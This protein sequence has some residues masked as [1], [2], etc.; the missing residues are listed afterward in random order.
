MLLDNTLPVVRYSESE[1]AAL[2]GKIVDAAAKRTAPAAAANADATA[3]AAAATAIATVASAARARPVE[4]DDP[5]EPI[6]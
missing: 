4:G 3:I 2:R 1:R 6:A 5:V